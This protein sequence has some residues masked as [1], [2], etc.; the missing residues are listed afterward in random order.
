M[1]IAHVIEYELLYLLIPSAL[2]QRRIELR[3]R[4]KR[5]RELEKRYQDLAE[6]HDRHGQSTGCASRGA[7]S[8]R[9]R[10]RAAART[11]GVALMR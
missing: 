4:K 11:T 3:E 8:A 10:T 6:L 5:E 9:Q 2:P 1:P 7:T